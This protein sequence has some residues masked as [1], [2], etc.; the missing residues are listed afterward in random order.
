MEPGTPL[1]ALRFG[2]QSHALEPGRDYLL[3]SADDCDLRIAD[4]EP[5]HACLSVDADG[6]TIS[7]LESESGLL[8]NEQRV[9]SATLQAGDR[10]AIAG[11]LLVLAVDDGSAALVPIPALRQAAVQRRIAKVRVAAAALRHQPRTFAE[12]V[13][14]GLRDAPWLALSIVLHALI[15]LLLAIYVPQRE[16]GGA[17]VA[18]INIDVRAG[19]PLGDG[20]PAPP[21]VVVEQAED[22]VVEDPDPLA[23]EVPIPITEGPKPMQTQPIEN[24]TL[25]TRKRPRNSGGGGG[26]V[27]DEGGIGSGSFQKKVRELQESGLEIVFVFDSTGSMTRT[28]QDTKSTIVEMCGVLR[29][30]VPDARIGLVTYRDR[31]RNEDYLVRQVPLALDYWRASNFVQF[32]TAEGGGDR[33][34]DVRAGLTAA[35]RQEWRPN[36]QRVIVLAGDAPAHA[37]D[38]KGMLKDVR[39]FAKNKRSFVHTLITSPER[40]GPTTHDHFRRIAE[41]GRGVCEPIENRGR[42]LQRVL[43]LAFG[44]QFDEDVDIV[45][46]T[47]AHQRD[48]VDTASLH[49]VRKGGPQLAAALRQQPVPTTLWN[50]LVRKPREPVAMVLIDLLADKRTPEHTRHASA[51]ALQRILRL[52]VPPIDPQTS[53]PASR[54]MISRLRILAKKLPN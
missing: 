40:A 27:A 44:Q 10:V 7:D 6:A 4:A 24:P 53:E 49:L 12:L 41:S 9:P 28:I 37:G 32:V 20:P 23:A 42:I 2:G 19:A 46:R 51:A 43:T 3:G 29:S 16:I 33:P 38:L 35:M 21:E 22:D 54:R 45:V 52:E 50:A 31:G 30:L 8:H 36:A 14:E 1:L 17:S 11:E 26:V 5:H 47:V 18:T 39:R 48:R 15:F 34:E 25:R 13:G